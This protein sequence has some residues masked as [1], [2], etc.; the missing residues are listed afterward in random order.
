MEEQRKK[1]TQKVSSVSAERD[2]S[3]Q[4]GELQ[5]RLE[6]QDN[7]L[8]L[9]RIENQAVF[10]QKDTEIKQ[11]CLYG[12]IGGNLVNLAYSNVPESQL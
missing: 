3:I 1:V 12:K 5:K 10:N 7:V 11:V 8:N 6:E 2:L 4:V 9:V